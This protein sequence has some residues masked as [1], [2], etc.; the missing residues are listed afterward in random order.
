M[1]NFPRNRQICNLEATLPARALLYKTAN[2]SASP[3]SETRSV[4][5]TGRCVLAQIDVMWWPR[6]VLSILVY[7]GTAVAVLAYVK[8][9]VFFTADRKARVIIR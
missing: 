1:Q 2:P 4:C 9:V 5:L 3:S 7:T 8:D 6:F